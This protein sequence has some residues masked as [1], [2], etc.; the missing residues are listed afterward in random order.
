[1][2]RS[3]CIDLQCLIHDFAAPRTPKDLAE[4]MVRYRSD[5]QKAGKESDM[6]EWT[7]YVDKKHVEKESDVAPG[8]R[9]YKFMLMYATPSLHLFYLEYVPKKLDYFGFERAEYVSEAADLAASL[10]DYRKP[11]FDLVHQLGVLA[12]VHL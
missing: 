9:M 3:L 8:D 5:K 2:W 6:Y 11:P 10:D 4:E 12:N 1:M 7:E